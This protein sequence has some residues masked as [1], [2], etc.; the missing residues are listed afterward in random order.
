MKNANAAEPKDTIEKTMNFRLLNKLNYKKAIINCLKKCTKQTR[1]LFK[2][3]HLH[4]NFTIK[5]D[6]IHI[7]K[8]IEHEGMLYFMATH[9]KVYA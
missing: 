9:E 5:T 4:D 1:K 2:L 8:S 7:L 3:F 6:N